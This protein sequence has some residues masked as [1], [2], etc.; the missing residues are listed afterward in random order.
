[1]DYAAGTPVFSVVAKAREVVEKQFSN[2][3]SIHKDGVLVREAVETARKSIAE[4]LHSGTSEIIFTSTG[5]ESDNLAILGAIDFAVIEGQILKP[6]IVTL[7]TEHPA[8]I[9]RYK[10]LEK[11][12]VEVTY[13]SVSSGGLVDPKDIRDALR[14]E[15][16]LVSV[17][18][19]NNEIGVV[20][21]IREIAKEIRHYRKAQSSKLKAESLNERYPL[22]HTDACQAA[23]YLN[24]NTEQLGVDLMSFSSI[25]LGGGHGA[26]VLY[27]K[28][29]TPIMPI[30]FGGSQERGLRPGT[31]NMPAIV[32]LAAALTEAEKMKE[33]EV[34]FLQILQSYFISE[35]QTL[36]SGIRINGSL[37]YR[38]PNNVH[39]SIPNI[40][41]ELL[42]LE[43][44]AKGISASAGSACDST[45]DVG[46]HV[47]EAL[48]GK[49]DAK[50]WGSVR[51]SF[52]YKTTR[53]EINSVI[54]A[55]KQIVEKYS[56]FTQ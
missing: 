39:V 5:T 36:F 56:R 10:N 6:H 29:G 32:A 34:A 37:E 14:P 4:I 48:Y 41:S 26:A 35:L 52:G 44:D 51:F 7:V 2:A 43:L 25:K 11:K 8:V 50:E 28:R 15:T 13:V 16:I 31:E 18:Y 45:K 30:L 47:L 49:D 12:G 22:F 1:M 9:E 46:S 19:A 20:Q 27:V 54:K 33:K 42:V 23:G 17:M 21:P 24:I 53:K 3:S 40:S 55:L 38:V